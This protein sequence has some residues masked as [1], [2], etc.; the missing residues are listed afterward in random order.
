M[1]DPSLWLPIQDRRTLAALSKLIEECGELASAAARCIAQGMEGAEPTTG[2]PNW[3]WLGEEMA[4]VMA[5]MH[6]VVDTV[7]A[8]PAINIKRM[9]GKYDMKMKWLQMIEGHERGNI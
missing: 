9:H 5:M 6:V 4:D 7:E 2:K 1:A 8:C 3:Q